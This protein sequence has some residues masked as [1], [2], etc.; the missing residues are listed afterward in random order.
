LR[1][2]K[3]SWLDN[4][5]DSLAKSNPALNGKVIVKNARPQKMSE[6]LLDFAKPIL[7]D[8]DITDTLVLRPALKIAIVAWNHLVTSADGQ[9][10]NR[11]ASELLGSAVA[12]TFGDPIGQEIFRLLSERKKLLYPDAKVLIADFDLAW[13]NKTNELHLTVMSADP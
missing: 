3:K 13:D 2:K 10:R 9:P 7:D 4:G 12:Q 11:R 6:I 5:I 1:H 8:I